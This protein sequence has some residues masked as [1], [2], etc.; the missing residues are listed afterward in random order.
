M[1]GTS[2]IGYNNG[3]FEF[4]GKPWLNYQHYLDRSPLM[5]VE[6]INTPLKIIHSELDFRCPIEQA[7]Q[8]YTALKWLKKTVIFVRFPNE[9]HELSRTGQP[10]HR[11][12]RLEHIISW[13][14]EYLTPVL[15]P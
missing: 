13:F 2:D 4:D 3:E 10:K 1:F 14:D 15:Q 12:E 5:Y 11:I 7:E 9:N 6:S 8:L